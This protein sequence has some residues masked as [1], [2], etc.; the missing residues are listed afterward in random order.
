[1][2]SEQ[3][4]IV[5]AGPTGLVLALWLVRLGV[6]V[7]IV[8]KAAHAA[9][10]SRAL[11]VQA[12]TLEFYRQLGIDGIAIR[13]GVKVT[14]AN[15]WVKGRRVAHIA[16]GDA[17]RGLTPYSFI[18]DYAQNE[19]ER[20]LIEQ[21]RLRGVE[22]ERN[23]E[24]IQVDQH[25][26]H[27]DAT[28]R[29][30]DGS[31]A[32]FAARYVAGCDGA[33][34]TVREL[35][36]I[37]FPGGTYSELFYVA[38]VQASGPVIDEQVHVD[39]DRS[40]L[41][42]VFAMKGDGHARLVGTIRDDAVTQGRELA[43]DDVSK[44]AIDSLRLDVS[45]VNWFSTYRV[46]HRV[47]SNFSR[48]RI[49]LLGDAAHIHSPVGAQGMN[50]GIGDSVNLAWKLAAVLNEGARDSLLDTYELERIGFARRLVATT[51]RVFTLASKRNAVAATIRTKVLPRIM[52]RLARLATV[53]R[54]LFRTV[55][56]IA[57]H[58]RDSPLSLR[59]SG[60]VKGGDRLPWVPGKDGG[61]EVGDNF[62]P[63]A[64]IA[65]QVHV[66]GK[67]RSTLADACA[68]LGLSLHVFRWTSAAARAGLSRDA[69][70]LIRPDGYIAFGD[71]SQSPDRLRSY[72]AVHY[73][74]RRALTDGFAT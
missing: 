66:Y 10:F 36:G 25:E 24:L 17:G 19:H 56:Q 26:D 29:L 50:T 53:R 11:G 64:S 37:G 38:D 9:P 70:Y 71:A 48:G 14:A 52:S 34:S 7:R 51:D 67:A 63:L 2:A 39:L 49:F 15:F 59:G 5:G 68:K 1:M 21:L 3:V 55:S 72:F 61:E 65:W 8:D 42:A 54:F 40:D 31:A 57:I 62:A 46:H 20:M 45:Q 33:R 18:L 16:F 35:L 32:T 41:L 73:T 30:P 74:H 43:F 28:V 58:Y 60:A 23:T 69:A 6:S 47:A 27:V 4:L 13:D 12:R 22:V 44:R